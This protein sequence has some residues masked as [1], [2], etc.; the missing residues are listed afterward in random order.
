M[1]ECETAIWIAAPPERVWAAIAALDTLHRFDPGV[2]RSSLGARSGPPGVGAT[3]RCDLARGGW[4]N[5]R[6]TEW[7]PLESIA[8][9]L[10]DGTAPLKRFAHRMTLR[11]EGDGT[12]VTR[13]LGYELKFGALGMLIDGV[14]VRRKF[15]EGLRA[16]F[17]GLKRYV[18][19]PAAPA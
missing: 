12:W 17:D 3:R 10:T 8:F 19:A 9:E 2:A 7:R 18:E 15:E 16:F 13:K 11:A 14:M 4:F 5:E 1:T 6:V